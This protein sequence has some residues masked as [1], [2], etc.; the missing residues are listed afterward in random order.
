[1]IAKEITRQQLDPAATFGAYR[2]TVTL[3]ACAV[4]WAV[5]ATIVTST[6][7]TQLGLTFASLALLTGAALWLIRAA[8]PLRAPFQRHSMIVVY[9]LAIVSIFLSTLGDLGSN[10]SIA[11]DWAPVAITI[12]TI[13]MTP[14]RP[15]PEMFVALGVASGFLAVVTLLT[16]PYLVGEGPALAFVAVGL[17][18]A[19]A[20]TVAAI[21]YSKYLVVG[22]QNWQ[23]RAEVGAAALASDMVGGIALSVERERVSILSRDVSPFFSDLLARD[24]VTEDDR[25]RARSIADAMRVMLVADANRTWLNLAVSQTARGPDLLH[26]VDSQFLAG[27]MLSRQRTALRAIL[28]AA[29]EDERLSEVRV[30]IHG[31]HSTACV[32]LTLVAESSVPARVAADYSTYFSVLRVVFAAFRVVVDDQTVNVRFDYDRP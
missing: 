11:D 7:G 24:A 12:L 30:S 32:L 8:H 19:V 31:E 3:A 21:L 23:R 26:V 1:M 2:T 14:Y 27:E 9:A 29:V 10:F 22:L 5:V 16:V 13:G 6:P 15:A 17:T 28:V 25:A 18:P 20:V 4:A